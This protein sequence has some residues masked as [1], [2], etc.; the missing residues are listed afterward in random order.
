MALSN[1]LRIEL[2]L[3]AIA[4]PSPSIA[5]IVAARTESRNTP[6]IQREKS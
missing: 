2:L 3:A 5:A 4:E 1:S 6:W